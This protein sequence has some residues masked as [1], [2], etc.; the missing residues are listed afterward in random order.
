MLGSQTTHYTR[1]QQP[2]GSSYVDLAGYEGMA[3]G[4]LK[5]NLNDY[6]ISAEDAD[7]IVLKQKGK[8]L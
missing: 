4:P 8:A 3:R 5:V 6:K 2:S 1:Y 7:T